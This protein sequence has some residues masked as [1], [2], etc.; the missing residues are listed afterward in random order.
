MPS[1]HCQSNKTRKRKGRD[2][3]EIYTD[4]KNKK[5]KVLDAEDRLDL[6]ADGQFFCKTC[7]R[8][9]INAIALQKHER[10]K[11]KFLFYFTKATNAT[12][13]H[14]NQLKRLAEPMYTVK[15]SLIAAGLGVEDTA[16]NSK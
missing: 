7:E 8:Y 4:L 12:L 9:F 2:I 6:P 16:S 5:T 15:D 13:A 3:D 14:K 11:R 10:S 1:K